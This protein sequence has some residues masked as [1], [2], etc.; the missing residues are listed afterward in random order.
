MHRAHHVRPQPQ[1]VVRRGQGG[2]VPGAVDSH[3]QRGR[4]RVEQ[5]RSAERPGGRG[6]KAVEHRQRRGPGGTARGR[7]LRHRG[8]E[9]LRVR[10]QPWH[11]Q[12]RAAVGRAGHRLAGRLGRGVGGRGDAVLRSG[13]QRQ[14][15]QLIVVGQGDLFRSDVGVEHRQRAG[16]GGPRHRGRRGRRGAA[17]LH[18]QQQ[19]QGHQ[20][21]ETATS[22]LGMPVKVAFIFVSTKNRGRSRPHPHRR[23]PHGRT[24]SAGYPSAARRR[25]GIRHQ[26]PARIGCPPWQLPIPTKRSRNC[27][28]SSPA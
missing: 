21:A 11:V 19:A 14:G 6:V 9:P 23:S 27:R 3:L 26:A 20:R 24:R 8:H 28:R 13:Q 18:G 2:R 17:A 22:T 1:R 16:R 25:A 7:A 15:Q 4:A 5:R 10:G 12:R